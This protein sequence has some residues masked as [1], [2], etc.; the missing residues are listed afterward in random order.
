ME[1]VAPLA[2]QSA[3]ISPSTSAMVLAP[4]CESVRMERTNEI[5]LWGTVPSSAL[6]T[7]PKRWNTARNPIR[8]A[9]AGKSASNELYA[10]SCERPMQSSA[11]NCEKLR[12]SAAIQS[13]RLSFSGPRGARPARGARARSVVVDKAEPADTCSRRSFAPATEEQTRRRADAAR[14]QE[15][16]SERARSDDGELCA[17]L[18]RDVR[19]VAQRVRG[20]GELVALGLEV[21]AN[22][23]DRAA[24]TRLCHRSSRLPS[25][26]S[27]PGSRTAG[28]AVCPC[29]SARPRACPAG[30]RARAG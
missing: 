15:P 10:I 13:R 26:A 18:R 30:P 27:P 6:S 8:P 4:P 22:V 21:A 11:M 3:P 24:V 28:A 29:G 25:S 7:G 5:T 17:E 19:C 20:R 12:F 9:S 23:V 14:E 2:A 1:A 16:D